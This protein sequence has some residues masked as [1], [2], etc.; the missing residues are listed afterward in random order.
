MTYKINPCLDVPKQQCKM[1]PEKKCRSVPQ[2][3]CKTIMEQQCTNV[4]RKKCENVPRQECR[5]KKNT[6][7]DTQ[8]K[9]IR[10]FYLHIV[11]VPDVTVSNSILYRFLGGWTGFEDVWRIA[12]AFQ[13]AAPSCCENV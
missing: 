12:G 6:T 7:V 9:F 11:K 5:G 3:K 4:P 10:V 2:Q 13:D 1:V 8:S